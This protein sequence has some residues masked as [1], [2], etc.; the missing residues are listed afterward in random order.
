MNIK[1]ILQI[2]GLYLGTAIVTTLATVKVLTK[3]N[4]G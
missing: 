4:R 2:G 3:K 1:N